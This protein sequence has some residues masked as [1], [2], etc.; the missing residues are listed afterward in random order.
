LGFSVLAVPPLVSGGATTCQ[1]QTDRV[2]GGATSQPGLSGPGRC[3]C[4][5]SW[6]MGSAI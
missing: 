5:G 1:C 2:L 4:L 3:H 6:V